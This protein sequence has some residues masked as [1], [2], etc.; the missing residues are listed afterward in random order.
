[1][2]ISWPKTRRKST[3]TRRIVPMGGLEPE[4]KI[5]LAHKGVS[6]T[7]EFCSQQLL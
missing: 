2:K 3:V 5:H 6:L 7:A 1:M 4:F